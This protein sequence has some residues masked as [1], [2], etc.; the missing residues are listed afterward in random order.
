MQKISKLYRN[1]YDVHNI[2]TKATYV[3]GEWEYD[4][5]QVTNT[6]HQTHFNESAIV[7]GNGIGR[8]KFDLR[9]LKRYPYSPPNKKFMVSYG[10][11][12]LYRDFEPDYL[13][14]TGDA[15]AKEIT[16]TDYCDNH[17]VFANSDIIMDYPGKFHIIPQDPNWNAGAIAAYLACFDGHSKVYLLGFDGNDTPTY[18]N[19]VYVDTNGYKKTN[20]DTNDNYW[21]IA[22]INI[23]KVYPTVDF[24]LVNETGKGYM[25]EAL[26]YT[27]MRRLSFRQFV[28][29]ADI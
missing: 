28:L 27:S 3:N 18:T 19:N 17:V 22:L 24:V 14:V 25:P 9:H 23:M 10:C 20:E 29:E 21:T 4:K 2:F 5:E 15:I 8:L 1:T 7:I 12:A 16:K 13:I 11:N 6:L 26:K